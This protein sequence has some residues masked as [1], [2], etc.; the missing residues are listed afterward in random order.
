MALRQQEPVIPRVFDQPTPVLTRRCWRLVSDHFSILFESTSR[1]H[2]LPKLS[3]IR[4]NHN[5]TS[6]DRNRW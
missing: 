4:L 2:R 5:L 6:F 3:A 1:R